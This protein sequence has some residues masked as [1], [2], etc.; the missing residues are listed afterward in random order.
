MVG[1]ILTWFRYRLAT[2]TVAVTA[3][4][5]FLKCES[6]M[7]E[8]SVPNWSYKLINHKVFKIF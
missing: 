1:R 6:L 2:R 7:T 5:R 3:V 8:C 4:Q